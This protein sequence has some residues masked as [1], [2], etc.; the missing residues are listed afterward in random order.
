MKASIQQ[1]LRVERVSRRGWMLLIGSLLL[2]VLVGVAAYLSD[3]DKLRATNHWG[4]CGW[5]PLPRGG[6]LAILAGMSL[7]IVYGLMAQVV[8]LHNSLRDTTLPNGIR[9]AR[10]LALAGR[11]T[12]IVIIGLYFA[13]QILTSWRLLRFSDGIDLCFVPCDSIVSATFLIAIGLAVGCSPRLARRHPEN[14]AGRRRPVYWIAWS[15][16]CLGLVILL[17]VIVRNNMTVPALV[18][19]TIAGIGNA[20]RFPYSSD[21]FAVSSPVRLAD[22]SAV[23]ATGVLFAIFS[24]A[25]LWLLS[26][27]WRRGRLVRALAFV[28]LAGSLTVAAL[29]VGRIV[30]H[31][32]PAISPLMAANIKWPTTDQMALFAILA[33]L[34]IGVMAF[35][36]SAKS[37]AGEATIRP[38]RRNEER[39][40][41]ERPLPVILLGVLLFYQLIPLVRDSFFFS[42]LYTT[43]WDKLAAIADAVL[44]YPLGTMMLIPIVLAV[45]MLLYGRRKPDNATAR[46]VGVDPRLFAFSFLVLAMILVCAGPMLAAFGFSLWFVRLS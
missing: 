45:Q 33:S 8:D 36:L 40:Y 42:W 28:A 39:Y 29:L 41:H 34:L 31:E 46:E 43:F 16:A 21:A 11:L 18:H 44:E 22:F 25:S 20:Q 2:A 37:S 19:M 4:L 38:W 30:G 24:L 1:W 12:V 17:A 7:W 9:W 15:L 32:I 27:V 10:R 35:R 5:R 6:E 13:A 3:L 14:F 23:A 26:H